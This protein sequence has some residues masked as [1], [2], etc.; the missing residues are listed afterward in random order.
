MPAFSCHFIYRSY[1][2]YIQSELLDKETLR[3]NVKQ[4]DCYLN[5]LLLNI[6]HPQSKLYQGNKTGFIVFLFPCSHFVLTALT[7]FKDM[8]RDKCFH[9]FIQ[10]DVTLLVS[11][12]ISLYFLSKWK[13]NL[14]NILSYFFEICSKTWGFL[15]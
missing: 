8:T 13:I 12:H 10:F 6:K 7:W 5:C 9:L 4:R 3:R 1:T 2:E 15:D 11:H 14:W